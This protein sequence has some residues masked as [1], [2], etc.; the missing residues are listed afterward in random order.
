MSSA[1]DPFAPWAGTVLKWNSIQEGGALD[2]ISVVA[3][4]HVMTREQ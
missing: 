3:P 4:T 1:K 2:G